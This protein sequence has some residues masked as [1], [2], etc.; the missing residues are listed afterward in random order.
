MHVNYQTLYFKIIKESL[1][2]V[3]TENSR[4]YLT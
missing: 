3:F 4:V 2:H 1:V